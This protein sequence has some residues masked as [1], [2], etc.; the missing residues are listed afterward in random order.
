MKNNIKNKLLTGK[1]AESYNKFILEYHGGGDKK[2]KT[3]L[4]KH[5]ATIKKY[6]NGRSDIKFTKKKEKE[7][8][9]LMKK[10]P[11]KGI[12]ILL[13]IKNNCDI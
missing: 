10:D 12:K 1:E 5:G 9:E 6:K 11:K 8:D 3:L 13:D 2:C 4:K 7:Y